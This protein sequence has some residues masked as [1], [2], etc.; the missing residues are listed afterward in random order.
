M[1]YL[2]WGI[3][4]NGIYLSQVIGVCRYLS[5]LNSSRVLL[6]SFVP[7]PGY[8][9][10]KNKIRK[11]YSNSII[12]PMIPSRN[13]WWPLFAI[14]SGLIMINSKHVMTRGVIAN[15]I[16]MLWRRLGLINRVTYDGRGA[17]KAEWSEYDMVHDTKLVNKIGDWE[18]KA[19]NMSNYRL[20]V[21]TKLVDYWRKEFGYIGKVFQDHVIIPCTINETPVQITQDERKVLRSQYDY[22]TDDIILVYSGS[23]EG[24]QSFQLIDQLLSKLLTKNDNVRILF[25]AKVDLDTFLSFKKFKDRINKMWVDPSEVNEILRMCDYGLLIRENTVTNQVASPTKFAEYLAAGLKVIIS[26]NIGDFSN[27][28]VKFNLGIVIK[29]REGQNQFE[30]KN[31]VEQ[32][33]IIEFAQSHFNKKAFKEEYKSLIL[34]NEKDNTNQ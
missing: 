34:S 27:L 31:N 24:W 7:Y 32:L 19:V 6:I 18:D 28:V 15:K 33:R 4:F 29:L 22:K 23:S 17:L 30:L 11:E 9:E 5:K 25:L 13:H 1:V 21:S 3:G 26:E 20:A 10:T 8:K 2:T 12:I 16:A 14:S